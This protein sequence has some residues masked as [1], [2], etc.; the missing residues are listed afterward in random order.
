MAKKVAIVD[1]DLTKHQLLQAVFENLTTAPANPKTGQ[2]YFDTTIPGFRVWNGTA[3][4]T[5]DDESSSRPPL[6]HV[7]ATN[8]ALGAEHTISG[9]SAGHALIADDATHAKFQQMDHQNLT[10]KGTNT[11]DSIDTHIGT[12]NIHRVLDDGQTTT[13]NLWSASKIDGLISAINSLVA[14]GLVNKGGY[15]AA[16]NSPLLDATPIAGIKNGWTYVVTVAGQF[17]TESVQ[18]G[19][20]KIHQ[21]L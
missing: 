15:D 11:H 16:T 1:F 14:G 10:N 9:A 17:F 7:L 20:N 18:V 12:A 19:P 21:P 3:W 13:T 6:S 5:M 4:E 8:A 2:F